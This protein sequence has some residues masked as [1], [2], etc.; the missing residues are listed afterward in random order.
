MKIL[1]AHK[2]QVLWRI[3]GKKVLKYF[4]DK[5]VKSNIGIEL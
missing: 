2:I 3:N 4:A 5:K 1:E